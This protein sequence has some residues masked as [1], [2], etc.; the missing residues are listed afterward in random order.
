M[1]HTCN[2]KTNHNVNSTFAASLRHIYH[3]QCNFCQQQYRQTRQR[4]RLTLLLHI[5]GL[6]RL[7]EGRAVGEK[8]TT[9]LPYAVLRKARYLAQYT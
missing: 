3:I 8:A 7:V 5:Y 9:K 2:S 4:F 6:L 1:Q